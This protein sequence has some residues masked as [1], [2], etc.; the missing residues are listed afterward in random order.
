MQAAA[1]RNITTLE[2]INNC[3]HKLLYYLVL[4]DFKEDL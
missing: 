4:R 2:L 1:T 3:F